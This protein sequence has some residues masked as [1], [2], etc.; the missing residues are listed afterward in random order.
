M[1]W[2][3]VSRLFISS[4]LVVG[5]ASSAAAQAPRPGPSVRVAAGLSQV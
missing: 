4:A 1:T 5:V 2:G 3:R